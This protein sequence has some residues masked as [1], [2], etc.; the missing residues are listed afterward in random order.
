MPHQDLSRTLKRSATLLTIA[1][2]VGGSLCASALASSDE[3]TGNTFPV[4]VNSSGAY[5]AAS[6]G[7]SPSISADGR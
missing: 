3:T 7:E 2:L 5:A 1:T 6:T 4:S